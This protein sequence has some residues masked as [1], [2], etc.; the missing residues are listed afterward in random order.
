[1]K[2]KL[3]LFFFII[4]GYLCA[5][6]G[7]L[8]GKVI[9]ATTQE[10][11]TGANILINELENKGT[12]TDEN[13]R[14]L[15]D[16]PVG[17]YSIKASIIGYTPSIKTDIVIRSGS[18]TTT[19]I[20]LEQTSIEIDEIEVSADY[21]DETLI[22]NN[23][24]TVIL[25]AEEVRRSPGSA[26]DFQRILQSM[27]GVSFSND[28]NNELL[29]RGGS[30]N[31]NLTVL[32]NIEIHSTNH[33]PNEYNSG[34]PINMVN[35]DLIKDIQFSTGGF[36]SKY[37]DKLSS[38]MIVESREGS[39]TRNFSSNAMLS[40]A[41]YG[42]VFEGQIN[43]GKGSWLLSAR[44]S[45]I[46]MI[47]GSVGLTAVPYYY[48]FQFKGVYDLSKKHKLSLVGIYGNDKINIE[49]ESEI[50]N[51]SLAG[52]KDTV[53][54]SNIDVKQY[55]YAAGLSLKSIWSNKFYSIITVS[56]NNYNSD[57]AVT[58]DFTERYYNNSGEVD[59]TKKLKT[60]NVFNNNS[61]N[62]EAAL[63]S[64][65]VLN[66]NKNYELSFGGSVKFI[67]FQDRILVDDDTV[68]YDINRDGIFDTTVVLA[69]N[70][71]NYDFDFFEHNK[72]YLYLNNKF[73]LLNK[74]LELNL[75]VRYDQFTYSEQS[76]FSPRISASYKLIPGI[77]S[78]N[79]AYGSFYQTQALPLYGDRFQ[80]GI[81]RKLKNS[82]ATHYVAGM[83]HILSDGL[84]LTFEGYYKKY[85]DIPVHENFIHFND[86]TTRSEK[87]VNI[88]E[89]EVY[90]LDL[91]IQQKL[92]KDIYGTL[93][94]SKMWTEEKDPRI[95]Y[96]GQTYVSQYDFPYV[97]T[98]IIGKRFKGLGSKIDKLPFLLKLPT[99]LLP[100]SDD[101]EI[102]L[103]WTYAS[104]KPY[105]PLEFV[106]T[107]QHRVGETQWTWGSWITTNDINSER[108]PDYHRLDI[109]INSRFNFDNWNLVV[110]LSIQ[111]LYNRKNIA[112]YKYNS[113][114][115]RE[116]LY[117]FQ[118]LPVGGFEIE[119]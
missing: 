96:E 101:M 109:G 105:T 62:G 8:S 35:V 70:I 81:N 42:G 119:L 25:G 48:D 45:Y 92:V 111:N 6:S 107:E 75:G 64:E 93:S 98:L 38:V 58:N 30:P 44:K 29:V 65:F 56:K 49:G 31:E 43:N 112:F 60:R 82:F 114:G 14:F 67:Q 108:Y 79:F 34:G 85:N 17:V 116:N 28:Q 2:T 97:A 18:E 16:L 50:T 52:K 89:R 80:T 10:A 47:A 4:S 115:T 27:A 13:G 37:G 11:L 104:G 87:Y 7:T 55:Q 1:M 19:E 90:G 57:V 110:F 95:G 100:F 83:E 41:G 61:D 22:E 12:A 118:F 72:S 77:T 84:K 106:T 5:Q 74:K 15:I 94:F 40:M 32:D 66:W 88:G 20:L 46:D 113:D 36:I 63:R 86:R 39:R 9:D 78:L 54:V 69:G 76:N 102:S 117:Q 26:Q 71:I 23:S 33:Y 73:H 53:D 59:N 103:K 91:L 3:F 21:F 68:R 24:S 99:Y 51:L